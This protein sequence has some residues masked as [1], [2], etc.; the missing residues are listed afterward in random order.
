MCTQKSTPL[1]SP[2]L[3]SKFP[4]ITNNTGRLYAFPTFLDLGEQQGF[5]WFWLGK[6]NK[7]FSARFAGKIPASE[8]SLMS[9]ASIIMI[10][11]FRRRKFGFNWLEGGKGG[12]ESSS[13]N[14]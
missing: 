7:S 8:W 4:V 5:Y 10:V 11:D 3:P 9:F 13:Q 1:P 14:R 2:R 6:Q 12:G